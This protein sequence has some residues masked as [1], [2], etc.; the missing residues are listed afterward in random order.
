MRKEL[1]LT[2]VVASI[3]VL[4]YS[5]QASESTQSRQQ[6][7]QGKKQYLSYCAS[8]HGVDGSGNGPAAS[9]LKQLPP[10]LRRIQSR[11]GKFPREDV[12]KKISG[13]LTVPVHGNKEMP[14]WGMILRRTDINDLIAYLES[15][16]RPFEPTPA[17]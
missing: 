17:D 3:C 8:C 13:A 4:L 12:R 6:V 11:L 16:Q 7:A 9:T 5:A 2:V 1:R 15:I 10:D 14:A